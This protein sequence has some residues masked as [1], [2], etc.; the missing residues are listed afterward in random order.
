MATVDGAGCGEGLF[1]LF[2]FRALLCGF[3]ERP[4][5]APHRRTCPVAQ[6]LTLSVNSQTQTCDGH[7]MQSVEC[8]F[9]S[10][11]ILM[12]FMSRPVL[13]FVSSV[14]SVC[15]R[16]SFSFFLFFLALSNYVFYLRSF[17]WKRLCFTTRGRGL[18]FTSARLLV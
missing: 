15:W 8:G 1:E 16:F 13:V 17:R 2:C 10:S 5:A 4:C 18:T 3:S 6:D 7:W 14:F 11:F 9:S 12:V